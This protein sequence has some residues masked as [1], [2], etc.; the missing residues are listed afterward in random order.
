METSAHRALATTAVAL[1]ILTGTHVLRSAFA[2]VV[3][4]IGEG[5]SQTGLLLVAAAIWIAGVAGW[6]VVP[7]IDSPRFG[8]RIAVL[9]A[10]LYAAAHAVRHPA[11]APALACAALVVWLWLVPALI[12][13]LGRPDAL[14]VLVPGILVGSG[15]QVALQT[16]LHG[17]DLSMMR[18]PLPALGAVGIAVALAVVW[19]ATVTT[20]PATAAAFPFPQGW[21]L[22]ALGPYLVLQQTLLTNLGRVQASSGL[23]MEQAAVLIMLGLAA[24]AA[25]LPLASRPLA[26]MVVAPILVALSGVP[27]IRGG[28]VPFAILQVAAAVALAGAMMPAPIPRLRRTYLWGAAGMLFGFALLF[29]F[30]SRYEWIELWP[31]MG[32]LVALASLPHVT[33]AAPTRTFRATAAILLIGAVGL[34]VARLTERPLTP[35]RAEPA[36][37]RAVRVL[38]YNIHMG[39]DARGVPDPEAIA[40]VIEAADADVVALQEVG[41][42]WTIN[43]GVDLASWLRWRFPG[44]RVVY[45]PMNGELWGNVILT[46]ME[47]AESGSLRFPLRQS[48]FQRGLTWAN[49]VTPRGLLLVVSTHFAHDSAEDRLDQAADLLR[50]W[51]NRERTAVLGDLNAPP[52]GPPLARLREGGLTD[53]LAPLGLGASPTWPAGA[54]SERIDYVLTSPD[55]SASGGL[56]RPT[57]AS[58]HLPVV[59]ELRV[60]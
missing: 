2:M 58:D 8:L 12:G 28:I 59:V 9:F 53:P 41:R 37:P 48:R 40:R 17:L 18:G 3:W 16:A 11:L 26:R 1:V 21:G 5:M 34:G 13:E 30:Y 27:F 43:G 54:P 29:L 45:G 4:N 33:T 35:P 51:N 22:F 47:V 49:V 23:A 7:W 14:D 24:A 15:L 19:R 36:D 39:F 25:A 44:Y 32:A 46:R 10:A 56:V 55:L 57:T 20:A 60:P 50:F 38:S 52:E 6:A 42:G 31:L